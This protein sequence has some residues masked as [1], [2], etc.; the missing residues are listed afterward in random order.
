MSSFLKTRFMSS[1]L[2]T[3]FMSSF[4]KGLKWI[5]KVKTAPEIFVR[6]KLDPVS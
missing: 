1:F 6:K 2:K 3:R 4:L 5:L